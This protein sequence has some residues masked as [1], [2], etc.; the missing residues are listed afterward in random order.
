MKVGQTLVTLNTS[1]EGTFLFRF[2]ENNKGK[3]SKQLTL[4]EG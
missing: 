3:S 4:I 2:L 1:V